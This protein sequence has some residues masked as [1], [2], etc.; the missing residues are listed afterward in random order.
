MGGWPCPIS[1]SS[2]GAAM[3]IRKTD[4]ALIAKMLFS[5]TLFGAWALAW[6]APPPAVAADAVRFE[7][8]E[9]AV[10]T[11]RGRFSFTVEMAVT[12]A[13]RQR[14]LQHRNA[15]A[16]DAGMLFDFGNLQPASMWMKNTLIPLDMIFVA[17]D[18]R[19]V[20]VAARNRPASLAV[21]RSAGAVRAVLE[22][23]AGT[24]GRLGVEAGS[25]ILHPLF[26]T[27]PP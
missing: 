21:I 3:T 20:N 8:S 15:L 14:G 25:L 18:G 17:G 23:N 12:E 16:P 5:V 22:V 6:T 13:Q 19:V 2:P 27:A 9:L 10:V 26:G 24:A 1:E 4:N 7:I 11:E